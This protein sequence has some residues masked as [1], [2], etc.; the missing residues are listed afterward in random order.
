MSF[1][2]AADILAVLDKGLPQCVDE[3]VHEALALAIVVLKQ[4]QKLFDNMFSMYS[5]EVKSITENVVQ[6]P[7]HD[8]IIPLILPITCT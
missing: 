1:K 5:Q 8:Q 4:Q 6:Q 2:Q 3:E 7:L